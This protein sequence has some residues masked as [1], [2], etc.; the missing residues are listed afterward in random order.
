MQCVCSDDF[1]KGIDQ[2]QVGNVHILPRFCPWSN[3]PKYLAESARCGRCF[4]AIQ[5]RMTFFQE[6][7]LWRSA[8]AAQSR[9][10]RSRDKLCDGFDQGADNCQPWARLPAIVSKQKPKV[11]SRAS[12]SRLRRKSSHATTLTKVSGKKFDS[13]K[14]RSR[15]LGLSIFLSEIKV[16]SYCSPEGTF[17]RPSNLS[18]PQFSK[19]QRSMLVESSF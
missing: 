17:V 19:V 10:N 18:F 13:R 5:P 7:A 12:C 11:S 15:G 8:Q 6:V 3:S 14:L 4:R 16:T 9:F 2:T 1:R